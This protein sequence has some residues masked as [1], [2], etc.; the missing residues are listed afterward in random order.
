M[1]RPLSFSAIIFDVDGLMLDSEPIAKYA[2]T[3][4][5]AEFGYS[6]TT[7]DYLQVLGRTGED[8]EK[9]FYQIFGP[10][11]PY[12]EIRDQK[13]RYIDEHFNNYGF[14]AKP[15]LFD[16][17]DFLDEFS[18]PRAIASSATRKTILSK[19]NKAGLGHR[20]TIIVGGDEVQ[21]GKPAPDI[22]LVAAQ[23]LKVQPN[24]CIVL[25]DSEAGIQAAHAAQM[26]PIMVP[27]LKPPSRETS[28]LAV[29]VLPSLF[30][31]KVFLK[32]VLSGEGDLVSSR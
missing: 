18:I 7:E 15:G 17:L 2:W 13:R 27:D 6:I 3:R 25:E 32:E 16:L 8:A 24:K 1:K 29:K 14:S 30:E 22:F 5:M 11:F 21:N 10:E 26:I 19:L 9:I 20:F 4:S 31:V 23:R 28:S 12:I